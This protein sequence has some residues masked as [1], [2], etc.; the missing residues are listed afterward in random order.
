VVTNFEVG[1]LIVENEQQGAQRAAYGRALLKELAASLTEEFGR[2]FSLTNLKLMRQFYLAY[3]EQI[4]QTLSGL[5]P[6]MRKRQALCSLEGKRRRKTRQ[7][8]N[9]KINGSAFPNNCRK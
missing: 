5:L 2:G 8:G 6:E 9:E 1:R 3:S 4:G 7:V